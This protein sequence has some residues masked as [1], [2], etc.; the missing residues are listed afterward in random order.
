MSDANQPLGD[1]I[2]PSPR[3]KASAGGVASSP[4]NTGE[5][6]SR[7]LQGPN[8]QKATSVCVCARPGVWPWGSASSE[9][10]KLFFS[11]G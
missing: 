4:G 5:S 8:R 2:E 3:P 6:K 1:T 11:L 7:S 10:G 9:A